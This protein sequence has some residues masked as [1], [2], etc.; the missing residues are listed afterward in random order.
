MARKKGIWV[1]TGTYTS[2]RLAVALLQ[3]RDS[4]LKF[5]VDLQL[6]ATGRIA[7]K[8]SWWDSAKESVWKVAS[9]V[10]SLSP[11]FL[12]IRPRTDL[13]LL[14][15]DSTGHAALHDRLAR[16]T[17]ETEKQERFLGSSDDD[18]EFIA[19]VN[20]DLEIVKLEL[21]NMGRL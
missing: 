16:L 18:L 5:T 1:I 12:T 2:Q 20:E 4:S 6:Y 17:G 19:P 11:N 21:V 15:I 14:R 8:V 10:G 3:E 7:P 13:M 9:S